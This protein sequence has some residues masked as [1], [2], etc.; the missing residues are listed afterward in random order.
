MAYYRANMAPKLSGMRTVA[1]LVSL[2][3]C[4]VTRAIDTTRPGATTRIQHP[5]GAIARRPAIVLADDG[6]LRFVE[7]LECPTEEL[8]PQA[9]TSEIRTEPNLAAVVVGVVAGTV[10]AILTVR[11]AFDHEPA[12]SPYLYGGLA[13][14][15]VGVPLSIGP[16]IGNRTELAAGTTTEPMRRPGPSEPCG[17]RP[18]PAR[19]AMLTIHGIEVQG[20][21][22]ATGRFSVSPYQLVD[23][24]EP[25]A[26]PLD[27]TALVDATAGARTISTMI[28]GGA[29]VSHAPAF[30][31]RGDFDAKIEPLRVVPRVSGGTPVVELMAGQLGV[32][33]SVPIKNDGPGD[34]Y[35]LRGHI[36]SN[37][38]AL[39]G[40]VLYVGHV[41]RNASAVRELVIPISRA[42]SDL[43]RGTPLDVS[44]E[45]HD[46]HATMTA[47]PLRFHG[48]LK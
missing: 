28:D 30:L 31:A 47:T 26:Q 34:V 5:E 33:I 11:G 12:S 45:L 21:I 36:T 25:T 14:L 1:L 38:P 19:A 27:I 42:A 6:S 24:F 13:G 18:L 7:P 43:I 15:A 35:A 20:T 37:Q 8:V 9:T 39:D 48:T 40:R 46:A 23:A 41:T 22:D 3:G 17:D 10:G 29:L 16:F 32:R 44:I 4:H 2:A